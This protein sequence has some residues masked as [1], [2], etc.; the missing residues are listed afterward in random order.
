MNGYLHVPAAL[1]LGKEVS[2][3]IRS[4]PQSRSGR[5]E[6]EKSLAFAENRTPVV[7][8]VAHCTNRAISAPF[9]LLYTNKYYE[10]IK[11]NSTFG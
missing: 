5:C 10:Y 3:P 4:G 6:E 8:P 2:V 11:P 7:Q 1:P 9:F